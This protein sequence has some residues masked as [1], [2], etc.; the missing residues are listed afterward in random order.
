[1]LTPTGPVPG[2]S[3]GQ[4]RVRATVKVPTLVHGYHR[5]IVVLCLENGRRIPAPIAIRNIR[6]GIEAYYADVDGGSAK[7]EVI[8]RCPRC[9]REFLR[10]DRN[11]TSENGLLSLPDCR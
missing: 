11:A 4:M 8:D 7:I 1:M 5:H 10:T 2:V 6:R 3:I 9:G